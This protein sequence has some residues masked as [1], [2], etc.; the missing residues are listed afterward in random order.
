MFNS[1]KTNMAS[2]LRDTQISNI[3]EQLKID[4]GVEYKIYKDSEGLRTFGIGHL[5]KSSDPE[6]K[7]PVGSKVDKDRVQAVFNADLNTAVSL[8]KSIYPSV[9]TWPG[10]VQEILVNMAFNLGGRL[11]N[12]Q[13]LAKAL[14]ERDWRKAADEMK[15][16]KWYT[17]VKG[18]GERLVSR[19]KNVTEK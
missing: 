12:F 11:R 14:N 6:D 2:W 8:T 15:D 13:K 1:N 19:M 18:R 5:I 10:E 7:L 4:E 9:D 16:S 3:T 17:Q